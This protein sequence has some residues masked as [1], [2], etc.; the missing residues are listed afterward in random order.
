M[1]YIKVKLK[2]FSG[3]GNSYRI[4]DECSK[5]FM[6]SG[7]E[8]EFSSITDKPEINE[9]ADLI[10]FCFPVYAFA[11]PRI[12]RKYLSALPKFNNPVRTFVLVTAGVE[13]ESGFSIGESTKILNSKNLDVVYSEVIQMPSNWTVS[14]NPPSKDESQ[15]IIDNGV[16]KTI[17]IVED[18]LGNT[19]S[20]HSFNYPSAYSRFVF[21][22]DYYLFRWLGVSSLWRYF[23][24][25]E[26]CNSCELC[27]KI[28]PTGSIQMIDGKPA[29]S[30]TCEQCMRCVNFCPQ[31]AIYQKHE[32]SIK[33]KNIYHEPDFKPLKLIKGN[34]RKR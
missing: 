12:C 29:W 16:K 30:K 5:A 2:Y 1:K 9:E 21:Y 18:I 10:G 7:H 24:T 13:D 6:K 14:M 8:V 34:K 28:C 23:R 22:R 4:L 33:G 32:G 20:H 31:K 26:T 17:K 27:S 19:E 3:T 15:I 25:D 11:I